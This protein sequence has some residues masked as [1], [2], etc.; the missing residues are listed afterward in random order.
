VT[1][2]I[3]TPGLGNLA[4]WDARYLSGDV[5]WDTGIVPPEVIA[6]VASPDVSRGWALDLGCG[7]G[8]TSRYL[9]ACG[10]RVIGIDLAQ[11]ALRRAQS[12]A[13]FKATFGYFVCASVADLSFLHIKASLAVDIGCFHSLTASER[14]SYT[15]SLAEHLLPGSHY[16]LYAFDRPAEAGRE[17]G[18]A[19]PTVAPTDIAAFAP[20]F[21]LQAVAHGSDRDR[22]AAWFLMRRAW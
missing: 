10:F 17:S 1:A 2:R 13:S 11:V 6:L 21:T 15:Q 7:S 19:T 12:I 20:S 3:E 18:G 14:A 9:A 8:V 4:G 16:L 22:P 5:P